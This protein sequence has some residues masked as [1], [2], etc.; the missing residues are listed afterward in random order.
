VRGVRGVRSE[1][2]SNNDW[3][4]QLSLGDSRWGKWMRRYVV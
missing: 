4:W 1:D 3:L 2:N